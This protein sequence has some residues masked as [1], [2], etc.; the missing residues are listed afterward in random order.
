MGRNNHIRSFES[1]VSKL[2]AALMILALCLQA[3]A[4]FCP[5]RTTSPRSTTHQKISSK[6]FSEIPSDSETT[7]ATRAIRIATKATKKYGHNSYKARIC[8]RALERITTSKQDEVDESAITIGVDDEEEYDSRVEAFKILLEEHNSKV[9]QLRSMAAT[10]RDVRQQPHGNN[11]VSLEKIVQA[12][13]AIKTHGFWADET[14]RAWDEFEN[15]L[16]P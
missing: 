14:K 7:R 4:F 16:S 5:I 12:Q 10:I 1:M 11:D 13:E 9:E 3:V 6:I 2:F 8:W 15:T